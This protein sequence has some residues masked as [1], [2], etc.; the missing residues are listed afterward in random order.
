[1]A[2]VKV[3]VPFRDIFDKV[4]QYEVGKVYE[5]EGEARVKNLVNRGWGEVVPEASSVPSA[6][7]VNVFGK[8]IEKKAVLD[9]LKSVGE[10]VPHLTGAPKIEEKIAELSD[11]KKAELKTIFGIEDTTISKTETV[12]ENV[13]LID[14]TFIE[15]VTNPDGS[16]LAFGEDNGEKV[17]LASGEYRSATHIYTVGD[18][19]EVSVADV[20]PKGE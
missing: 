15:V 5:F 13:E 3:I 6:V 16:Q 11:E 20:E 4:T 19:G 8:E 9:A 10:V 2:K 7:L 18:A 14:G 12:G 1:M 17:P